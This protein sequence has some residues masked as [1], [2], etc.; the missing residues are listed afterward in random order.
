MPEPLNISA[1]RPAQRLARR[2][3]L[4]FGE[5]DIVGFAACQ[6][7][8]CGD[9]LL[10]EFNN[11]GFGAEAGLGIQ[12]YVSHA[13]HIAVNTFVQGVEHPALVAIGE[14]LPQGSFPPIFYI[15][16]IENLVVLF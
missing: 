12:T 16:Y 10:N 7:L 14:Q 13:A 3:I 6:K 11:K 8:E 4:F 9:H 2:K 15:S 1:E 5:G